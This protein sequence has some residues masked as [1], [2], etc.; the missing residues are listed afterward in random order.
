MHGGTHWLIMGTWKLASELPISPLAMH[1]A[2]LEGLCNL[3]G[4]M[5]LIL[6]CRYDNASHSS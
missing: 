6:F 1:V 5:A 2:S 4:T 3:W